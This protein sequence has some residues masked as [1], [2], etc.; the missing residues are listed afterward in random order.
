VM[1]YAAAEKKCRHFVIDSFLKCGLPED[2]Y[3]AQKHF[4]DRICTVARDTGMHV[5]LVCHSRKKE[6]ESKPPRKMDVKGASSI[7]DQVDN[8]LL[9]WRN[10][11]KEEALRTLRDQSKRDEWEVEP[12]AMLISD[13]QRNGEWEGRLG[14]WFDSASLQFVEAPGGHPVDMFQK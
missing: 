6:D 10:K 11:P 12:D 4:V 2:D 14:F 7:T 13:K 1:G 5:H 3:N 9:W 8:V